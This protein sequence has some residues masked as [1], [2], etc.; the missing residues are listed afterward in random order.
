[1]STFVSELEKKKKGA[2]LVIQKVP[3]V[4]P[5]R[6]VINSEWKFIWAIRGFFFF[7]EVHD[8]ES[9]QNRF[10]FEWDKYYK[11]LLFFLRFLLHAITSPYPT[12]RTSFDIPVQVFVLLDIFCVRFPSSQNNCQVR[13]LRASS[14]SGGLILWSRSPLDSL[15][16]LSPPPPRSLSSSLQ[17]FQHGAFATKNIRTSEENACTAG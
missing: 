13:V 2:M 4:L 1:M 11:Y 12:G 17:E 16:P 3:H 6:E 9:F 10:H 14:P 7:W 8:F 15:D 5:H